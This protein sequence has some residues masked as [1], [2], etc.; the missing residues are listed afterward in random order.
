MKRKAK[1]PMTFWEHVMEFRRNVF[2]MGIAVLAGSVAGY[3][4][5]P[6]AVELLTA[7]AG[8]NLY[9]FEIATGFLVRI[10]IALAIGVFL[11]LPVIIFELV[12]FIIP[13]LKRKEKIVM[14]AMLVAFFVLFLGG[15]A[16]A[17]QSVIPISIQFLTS[18]EFFPE[19]VERMI[20]IDDFSSFFM[21]FL[22][23][24]GI[25]FQFPVVM[26]LLL[27]FQIVPFRFFTKNLR[28][29]I[30]IILLVAAILTPPDI[31]SQI[32]L[33]VPLIVLYAVSLL[34]AKIFG[35]GK[36]RKENG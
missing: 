10:K 30:V 18:E 25:C 2:I 23:G 19:K 16:F 5:F 17:F 15:M 36:V 14:L 12:L 1:A 20:S 28:Y 13:A 34:A 22:T 33:A 32:M 11:S 6:Y 31:V 27:K 3:F 9:T 24:F 4:A 35:L 26:L 21:S 8:E 7:L 29:F